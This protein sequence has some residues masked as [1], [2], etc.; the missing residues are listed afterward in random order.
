MSPSGRIPMSPSGR[1]PVS[2]SG[3]IP[4]SPS[5]RIPMSPTVRTHTQVSMS[6]AS[7][8]QNAL[9]SWDQTVHSHKQRETLLYKDI[10]LSQIATS[11]DAEKIGREEREYSDS[12]RG[13][14]KATTDVE[15]CV[16]GMEDAK[17]SLEFQ[18]RFQDEMENDLTLIVLAGGRGKDAQYNNAR[19]RIRGVSEGIGEDLGEIDK[20]KGAV[21]RLM[22]ETKRVRMTI[23]D[24]NYESRNEEKVSAVR[25]LNL[26]C[27]E[28]EAK[29]KDSMSELAAKTNEHHQT[30]LRQREVNDKLER[31]TQL[32][33]KMELENKTKLGSS[34][35]ELQSLKKYVEILVALHKVIDET[36]L[37]DEK[38]LRNN[39]PRLA[40]AKTRERM[41]RR[42]ELAGLIRNFEKESCWSKTK[43]GELQVSDALDIVKRLDRDVGEKRARLSDAKKLEK[44]WKA[45]QQKNRSDKKRNLEIEDQVKLLKEKNLR[46]AQEINK[47]PLNLTKA[48]VTVMVAELEEENKKLVEEC[49]KRRPS[50]DEARAWHSFMRYKKT[51]LAEA[52]EKLRD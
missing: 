39:L 44:E 1:I 42:K 14:G 33:Q 31:A 22:K 4:M 45:Q 38:L 25:Q 29:M 20:K 48:E 51:K 6:P 41:D 36:D 23:S 52:S 7:S 37:A 35:A 26:E 15:E 49:D 34:L 11:S 12:F 13:L 27:L 9:K 28:V 8:G 46:T 3:R 10:R 17:G 5:G 18:R 19:Q 47:H 2:P 32:F 16:K 30:K 43:T 21:E 40:K 24:E 50:L